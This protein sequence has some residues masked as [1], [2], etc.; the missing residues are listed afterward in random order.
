MNI[1]DQLLDEYRIFK[2]KF[3]CI[4][5]VLLLNAANAELVAKNMG[6]NELREKRTIEE[7]ANHTMFGCKI[8][9]CDLSENIKFVRIPF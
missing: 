8:W 1:K 9:L 2:D 7:M 6:I 5:N 4:P 3:G